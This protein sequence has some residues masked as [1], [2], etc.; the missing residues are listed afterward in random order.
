MPLWRVSRFI[1]CYAECR[2]AECRYAEC[3]YAECHYAECRSALPSD[4]RLQTLL[5][6]IEK[7]TRDKH[8]SLF[9]DR[10]GIDKKSFI[11]YRPAHL[12]CCLLTNKSNTKM[13]DFSPLWPI[14]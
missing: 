11:V 7:L 12:L 4:F 5:A 13:P 8:A 2:Y 10:F 3:R 6:N 1:Y 14:L 9:C